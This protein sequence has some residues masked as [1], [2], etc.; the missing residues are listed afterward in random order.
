MG[1]FCVTSKEGGVGVFFR[2]FSKNVL[3]V[4]PLFI[5]L[6]YSVTVLTANFPFR[7]LISV[8]SDYWSSDTALSGG[9]AWKWIQRASTSTMCLITLTFVGSGG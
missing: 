9:F 3:A 4:Y 6:S 8:E 7:S 1:F 5:H 2:N